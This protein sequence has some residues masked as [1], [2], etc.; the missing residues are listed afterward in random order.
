MRCIASTARSG[1]RGDSMGADAMTEAAIRTQDLGKVYV[2][3]RSLREI[4][5]RPFAAAETVQGLLDVTLEVRRGEIFGLL[6]LGST[7][8]GLRCVSGVCRVFPPF[9]GARLTAVL[10]F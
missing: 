3:R 10:R 5:M 8:G 1:T 7:R 6:L 2:K 4:A 9:E